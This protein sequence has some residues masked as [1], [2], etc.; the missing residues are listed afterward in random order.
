[1]RSFLV[2]LT[3]VGIG[4]TQYVAG[5]LDHH[6]LHTQ[7]DTESWDIVRTGVFCG[8]DLAFDTSLTESRTDHD[9]RHAFKS[10]SNV[11]FGEFLTIYIMRL[12][13]IVIIG[14]GM[15]QRFE[16]T[17]VSVLQIV[18]TNQSDVD[19]F[20]S[21]VATL[22][23]RTPWTQSRSFSDWHIHLAQ[24][25]LVQFLSLHAERYFVDGRHIQTLDDCIFVYITE[26]S[27]FFTQS[28]IQVVFGT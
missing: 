7:T 27:N 4:I 18:F 6:H 21:L 2:H 23:E 10:L 3:A 19:N 15:S 11:L 26:M 5:E 14:S 9:T 12:Y 1:M 25:D 22:Q 28:R 8:D 16:N 13:L 24:D 20:C 17:L